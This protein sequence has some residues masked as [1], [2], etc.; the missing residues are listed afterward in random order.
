MSAATALRFQAARV[1]RRLLRAWEGR[2]A[3][4]W[5]DLE[6]ELDLWH[7]QGRKAVFWWRD[8]DA[9]TESAALDRLL[10]LSDRLAMPL[11]LAV[12][13]VGAEPSLARRLAR[14]RRVRALQHGFDHSDH[15]PAG[16]PKSE[17]SATR[18]PE[19]VRRQLED[20]RSRLAALFGERFLPVLVPPFNEM[21]PH[22]AA[23]VRAAGYG[24]VSVYGDFPGL[25][26]ASRNIHL[27][28]IDWPTG[29]AAAV[30][31]NVR[32]AIAALRLRRYGI[33]PAEAPIGV[34]SHHLVH[35]AAIWSLA[36]EL[37]GRLVRHPAVIA[38]DVGQIF[39]A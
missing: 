8:D 19:E 28:I 5:E 18:S 11:G 22:L 26:V 34:V 31:V 21:S 35:D 7:R 17:L 38:P 9:R 24:F 4:G 1:A 15:A 37:L 2:Q 3:P 23:A 30:A 33:L 14:S 6:R 29:E 27:D 20:G 16:R 32:R 39:V 25:A 10:A 36:E 12:I 13:P